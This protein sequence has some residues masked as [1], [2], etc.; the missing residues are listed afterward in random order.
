MGI[1]SKIMGLRQVLKF[2][3]RIEL[4]IRRLFFTA[5]PLVEYQYKNHHFL[6]DHS[7]GDECGIRPCLIGSMYRCFIK[8][9]DISDRPNV[10]DI[11]ANAGG[12]S[13]MLAVDGVQPEKLVAVEMNPLTYSRLQLNLFLNFFPLPTVMNAALT[14]TTKSLSV[15]W[16]P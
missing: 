1:A 4:F 2:D 12:F 9:L 14:G 11:G 13:L 5:S 6:I 16:L 10:L 8:Q 15:R 7:A 3:N